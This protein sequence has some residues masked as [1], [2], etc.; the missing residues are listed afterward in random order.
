MSVAAEGVRAGKATF[1]G[2]VTPEVGFVEAE[3]AGLG[4]TLFDGCKRSVIVPV[5]GISSL[6]ENILVNRFFIDGLS[7][8]FG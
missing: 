6:L 7:A 8:C 2:V 4:T 1:A 3:G 5:L